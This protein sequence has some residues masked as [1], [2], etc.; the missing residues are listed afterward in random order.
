MT[1]YYKWKRVNSIKSYSHNSSTHLCTWIY[2]VWLLSIAFLS[3]VELYVSY[4]LA[5]AH[6]PVAYS[7]NTTQYKRTLP[8]LLHP[9]PSLTAS[10]P[11]SP[12][13]SPPLPP[14]PISTCHTRL[15]SIQPWSS[16]RGVCAPRVRK[17]MQMYKCASTSTHSRPAGCVERPYSRSSR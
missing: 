10:L 5:S 12:P 15:H 8:P 7:P 13:L 4:N 2:T 6:M 9:P 17:Q 16:A 11:L 14:P 3:W 1:A